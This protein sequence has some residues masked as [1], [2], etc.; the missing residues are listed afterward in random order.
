MP[1]QFFIDPKDLS[2]EQKTRYDE[3]FGVEP[4]VK[5]ESEVLKLRRELAGPGAQEQSAR[6]AQADNFVS[7][8]NSVV[9][10]FSAPRLDYKP[11]R[12]DY[13]GQANAQLGATKNRLSAAEDLEKN[14]PASEASKA[15]R[16][17]V[18]GILPSA[19]QKIPGFDNSSVAQLEKLFPQLLRHDQANQRAQ[20]DAAK[21]KRMER[22]QQAMEKHA[23]DMTEIAAG[24]LAQGK[25]GTVVDPITGAIYTFD[26]KTGA[27][28]HGVGGTGHG[29][30]PVKPK[31]IN[32]SIVEF[33]EKMGTAKNAISRDN[34]ERLIG[35]KR[36]EAL[37]LGEGGH[38]ENLTPQMLREATS[39]LARLIS[40]GSVA[41]SQIE[42]LTPHTMAGELA[43][44]MQFL[45]S[46]PEG[47]N[48]QAFLA[49]MLETVAREKKVAV[50]AVR[51]QQLQAVPAYLWMRQ[52]PEAWER[53]KNILRSSGLNPDR[54]DDKGAYG[55]APLGE[56]EARK[57]DKKSG[58]A[59]IV[60]ADGTPLRWEDD[61]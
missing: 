54:F 45:T 60:G 21:D 41:V 6:A 55:P 40:S 17:Y 4:T 5:P 24:R 59:V 58:R 61:D 44:K 53:M 26:R 23:G 30:A 31:D 8:M 20:L 13:A 1:G 46:E 32:E 52:N 29:T 48:A 10:N 22:H 12:S 18:V 2:D 56:G 3:H 14:D 25:H 9:A 57:W 15:Y 51:E 42:E 36:L 11:V 27:L 35:A 34:Q 37:I 43:N 49:K 19:A 47:A 33:Q 28:T 39:T 50:N 16:N 38:I 7:G